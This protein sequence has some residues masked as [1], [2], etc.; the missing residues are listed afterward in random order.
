MA[1]AVPV[2]V[3]PKLTLSKL[4]GPSGGKRLGITMVKFICHS[5]RT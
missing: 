1:A 4:P 5:S 3:D 2:A